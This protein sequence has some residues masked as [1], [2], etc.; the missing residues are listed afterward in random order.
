MWVSLLHFDFTMKKEINEQERAEFR[1]DSTIFTILYVLTLVLPMLLSKLLGW[2]GWA[3]WAV[4][5]AVAFYYG[6]RVDR[7]K[8][9]HNIQTYKE[10]LAFTEG[11]SLSEIEQAREEGKRP[12]Q[13]VLFVVGSA[14]LAIVV[15]VCMYFI[16][17]LL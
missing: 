13:K 9:E 1:K 11:K 5:V 4:I 6:F 8:K 7:H 15:T 14:L 16:Y 10:I 2:I 17:Q 12:Y 3:I